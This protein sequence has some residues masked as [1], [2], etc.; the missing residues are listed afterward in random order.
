MHS[1]SQR[2]SVRSH[3][4]A[5]SFITSLWISHT[6]KIGRAGDCVRQASE[7]QARHVS[8]LA[9]RVAAPGARATR[10]VTCMPAC[11]GGNAPVRQ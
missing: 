6:A 7:N 2:H 8:T 3:H 5:G 9:A 1:A 11:P 4:D 10:S